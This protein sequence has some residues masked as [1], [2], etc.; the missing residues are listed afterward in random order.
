MGGLAWLFCGRDICSRY[1]PGSST[2][3]LGE[4]EVVV[5]GRGQ[6]DKGGGAHSDAGGSGDVNGAGGDARGNSSADLR[7]GADTEGRGVHAIESDGGGTG[8]VVASNCN[9]GSGAAVGGD[10]TRDRWS[11]DDG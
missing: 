1:S 5:A 3:D 10:E 7:S 9:H 4:G 6:S 8:E 11:G 2:D